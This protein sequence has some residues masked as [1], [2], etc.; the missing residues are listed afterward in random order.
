MSHQYEREID[1]LLHR[2]E[3]RLRREP[4]SRRLSR[5]F[6]PLSYGLRNAFSAFLRRPPTE[7]FMITAMFLVVVSFVMSMFGL[8]KWAFFASILSIVFF[9]VG[10]G[11]SVIG[12]QSPGYHKRWR[13]REVDYSSYYG[14]SIWSQ[15]RNWFRRRRTG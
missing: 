1:E 15:L 11:P 3:G 2:M 6:G 8:G 14:P 13:G 7:Q 12:R 9:L 10:I 4:L 5:R